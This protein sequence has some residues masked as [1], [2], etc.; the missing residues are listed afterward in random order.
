MRKNLKYYV[1]GLALLMVSFVS[2][3]QASQEVSPIVVPDSSY[4]VV[5]AL[6]LVNTGAINEGD[7]IVYTVSIN[8]P[9]SH[10]LTFAPVLDTVATTLVEHVDFDIISATIDPWETEGELWIV[11]YADMYPES[12]GVVAFSIIVNSLAEMY[13]LHPDN[14]FPSASVTVA[15]Y[16]SNELFLE[17]AWD[18]DI[19]L[20]FGIYPAGAN[21]DF[22][23]FMSP[24][25]TYDPSDPWAS[26]D[27]TYYAA[28]GNEPELID[29]TGAADGDYVYWFDLWSNGFD[30]Y[31][32]TTDI[33]VTTTVIKPGIFVLTVAQDPNYVINAESAPP[34]NATLVKI[35]VSGTTYTVTDYN[36]VAVGS[37]KATSE[38]ATRPEQFIKIK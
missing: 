10:S 12:D 32:N 30:G 11:T 3:D 23:I 18:V 35:N 5:E 24:G 4:P 19:D 29:M 28:T 9:I 14:V 6:T 36:D 31:G 7:T 37:G 27:Y 33:P 22:D 16:I 20:G 8:K 21:V 26:V 13:L 17:F 34:A 15:N 1:I 2:C 38:R 25:A